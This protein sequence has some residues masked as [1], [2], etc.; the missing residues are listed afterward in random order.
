M[1]IKR[2]VAPDMRSAFRLVRDDQGPTAVI[3]SSRRVDGGVEI[4]AATDYDEALVQQAV[5]A[6]ARPAAVAAPS[7]QP[8]LPRSPPPLEP[9]PPREVRAL[10]ANDP[11]L[12]EVRREMTAMRRVLE[13]EVGRFTE[14]RLKDNPVR[15][16]A[17]AELAEYGCEVGL[18]RSIVTCIPVDADMRRARGL[19]F[20]IMAKSLTVCAR[21][22]IDDG[23]IIALI[24]P[25]GVG[26]TT[27]IAKLAARYARL[28]SARDV[29][30]VTTDTY[31]IGAREQ[32]YTYGRLLGMPVIEV[33][34]EIAL[35]EA[36]KR[37]SDY[38]LILIDTAGLS[39]RDQALV[40]QLGWLNNLPSIQSYLVLP[41]NAQ[42]LDLDE[43]VH[44]FRAASPKGVI[45]TKLDETG[46][47]AAAL[48]LTIRQK[49]PIAYVT[50]GQRVPEDLHRAEAHRLALRMVELRQAAHTHVSENT[51]VAA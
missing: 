35:G 44:R 27:T 16:A 13:R 1:K 50:D 34:N 45:L 15:A 6:A 51:H 25:T 8:E 43:V 14:Q 29:A 9:A 22:P 23:G 32:L 33:A 48:S 47:L 28:H 49:L 38:R 39:L 46:R 19:L 36:L 20:G 24:G 37:L 3:L 18:A 12:T 42:P 30:I 26:K 5:R 4:V 2:F 17:L 11:N 40:G 10:W 21:E 31:R 7:A 41:A